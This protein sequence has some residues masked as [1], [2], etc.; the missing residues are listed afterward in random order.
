MVRTLIAGMFVLLY[1]QFKGT[2][3]EAIVKKKWKYSICLSK[4]YFSLTV[5]IDVCII[6]EVVMILLKV[7]A[8]YHVVTIVLC[9][10][11]IKSK[12]ASIE[13]KSEKQIRNE[14]VKLMIDS[15]YHISI[16]SRFDYFI[17][18][19]RDNDL[20]DHVLKHKE[21]LE[22]RIAKLSQAIHVNEFNRFMTLIRR[23]DYFDSDKMLYEL[24]T[25]IQL[26]LNEQFLNNKKHAEKMNEFFVFPMA[27]N[28]INMSLMLV[29]PYLKEWF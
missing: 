25:L 13:R 1:S 15:Y 27:V 7:H 14:L 11:L 3:I 24:E 26:T 10:S 22:L 8:Y 19:I 28:L 18:E 9:A 4:M 17:Y 5:L 21:P 20:I 16:G 23:M 6:F 29:Y 12:M 2:M